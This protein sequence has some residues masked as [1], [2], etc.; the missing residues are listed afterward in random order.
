MPYTSEQYCCI[1]FN[2]HTLAPAI[3]NLTAGQISVY[4]IGM[5]R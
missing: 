5:Q 3:P 1:A 4:V 2:F